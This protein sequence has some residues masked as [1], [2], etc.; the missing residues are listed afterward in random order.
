MLKPIGQYLDVILALALVIS[1]IRLKLQFRYSAIA[2]FLLVDSLQSLVYLVLRTLY[3]RGFIK[4]S[5]DDYDLF[6]CLVTWIGWI[7]TVWLVYSLLIA[8]LQHLPGILRFS[9]WFFAFSVVVSVVIAYFTLS[10]EYGAAGGTSSSL[11]RRL[12]AF[13]SV[14]DQGLSMAQVLAILSILALVLRFPVT[15]PRNLA[16][17]TAGLSGYLFFRIGY[18]LL[19]T[20]VPFFRSS[21]AFDSIPSYL[22]GLCML[23]WIFSVDAS[24]E[25]AQVTLGQGWRSVPKEHLVR[26][27]E[28]MNAA[29][30]RSREQS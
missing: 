9:L 29:L 16:A 8:I 20:Y 19:H 25:Q 24:G 14:A 23:Y 22:I 18:F 11:L 30:L 21:P 13:T 28:A 26:Q 15:M 3:L 27:L 2:V 6:W 1:L 4:L 12:V 5:S 7:T 17:F 10:P